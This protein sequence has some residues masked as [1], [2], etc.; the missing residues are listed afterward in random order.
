MT[1][2]DYEQRQIEGKN[3]RRLITREVQ[4]KKL[5]VGKQI[6]SGSRHRQSRKE[7]TNNGLL[8]EKAERGGG[9]RRQIQNAA[10]S[11]SPS[12]DANRV[13]LKI[14]RHPTACFNCLTCH[15]I[16][17]TANNSGQW[18]PSLNCDSQLTNGRAQA[19]FGKRVC[20]SKEKTWLAAAI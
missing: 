1:Q 12:T 7:P 11:R 3:L 10:C 20:D 18:L 15:R 13:S 19:L 5:G 4:C 9:G 8:E 17:P 2:Q 14:I 6:G 16:D